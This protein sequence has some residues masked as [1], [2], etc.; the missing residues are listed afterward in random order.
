MTEPDVLT[1]KFLDTFRSALAT[2]PTGLP[3]SRASERTRALKGSGRSRDGSVLHR[4]FKA[5][6]YG[7]DFDLNE[8]V[9]G[10]EWNGKD[11]V[12]VNGLEVPWNKACWRG[13]YRYDMV[14]EV[15]NQLKEFEMTMRGMFDIRARLSVGIFFAVRPDPDIGEAL[16][17]RGSADL[18]PLSSWSPPAGGRKDIFPWQFSEGDEVLVV[19]L[20]EK[21]PEIL[22]TRQWRYEVERWRYD[23]GSSIGATR[24]FP[25]LP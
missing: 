23:G 25:D 22:V 21:G 10:Y 24:A 11:M 18:R 2:V 7:R 6:G 16:W 8:R 5:L 14:C 19:V 3:W 12:A 17:N 4:T 15:E 20:S 13:R 9:F 1:L